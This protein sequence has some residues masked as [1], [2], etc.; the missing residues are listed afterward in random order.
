MRPERLEEVVGQDHLIGPGRL[1]DPNRIARGLPSLIFWGPPGSGKTTL[2]LALAHEVGAEFVAFSAVL[3]GLQDV[4]RVV[5]QARVDRDQRHVQTVL[6]VDEIHRFNKAQQDAFLPHVESGLITLLGA[7]TENPSFAIISALLSRCRVVVLNPLDEASLQ[8][9]L[10]RALRDDNSGLGGLNLSLAEEAG[11]HLV[12][13]A[14]GDARALLNALET[15]AGLVGPGGL[16][17]LEAAQE[18]IGRRALMYDRAGEEHYNLIS[19]FHKSLRG[20]DPD[21]AL[22]WLARML[23]AGADP[24]YLGRRMVRAA[25]E[26]VGNA[27][28]RALQIALAAVEAY[29]F[30]GSPEGELALAQAAVYLACAPK[31]NAV[32]VAMKQVQQAVEATGSPPTPLHLRNAPT[33][34]MKDLGYAKDYLYP[35]DFPAAVVAQTYLPQGLIGRRFYHPVERGYEKRIKERLEYWRRLIKTKPNVLSGKLK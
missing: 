35:H 11:A 20:S 31:S 3:V 29:R 26:D 10:Q 34:L 17:D 4:R 15:A 22:Y 13:A 24:F 18:A 8:K 12:A 5:A 21:A 6:F 19:A 25:S 32:Y 7:T 33:R 27:D 23:M 16:I 2:A 30:L 1:L 14:Q 28:P 9:I